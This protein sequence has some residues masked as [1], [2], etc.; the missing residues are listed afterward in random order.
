MKLNLNEIK[1][2]K[3]ML[4]KNESFK[5]MYFEFE[6]GKGLPNHHH[7]G[8]A[9]I[10]VL[11]GKVSFNFVDG[12]SCL[13]EKNDFLPFDARHTHNVIAEEKSKVLVFIG[14]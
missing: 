3:L 8:D 12:E 14:L 13:L 10:Q 4:T 7:D 9:A 6:P 11:E 2:A 1:E 5:V